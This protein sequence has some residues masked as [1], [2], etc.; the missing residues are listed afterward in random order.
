MNIA[1]ISLTDHD[2]SLCILKDGEVH[3]NILEERLSTTK[4]DGNFF[5][6]SAQLSKFEQE[7]GLDKIYIA[8][9]NDE[10]LKLIELYLDKYNINCP[11]EYILEEHHLYH[12][13]SAYYSSGFDEAICLVMDGWGSCHQLIDIFYILGEVND[14]NIDDLSS[15]PEVIFAETTS[16]YHAKNNSF[17]PMYKNYFIPPAS[18]GSYSQSEHIP[19]KYHSII[20][21]SSL[22]DINPCTDIG[23]MYGTVTDHLGFSRE[24]GGKTMGL[25]AYG[26]EDPELPSFMNDTKLFGNSNLFYHSRLF[27]WT[28]HPHLSHDDNFQK[29]ANIAYKLQRSVEDAIVLRVGKILEKY[30]DTKNLAFSGGVALNICANSAIKKAY[31]DL[32]VFID[33]IASDACQAYGMAKFYYGKYNKEL[34]NK[35]LKTIYMGPNYNLKMKRMEIELAVAKENKR[36]YNNMKTR[37]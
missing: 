31:P 14:D 32:N 20:A 21:K 22:V 11:V 17:R 33:P 12:A 23:I 35:P 29:K 25:A 6:L 13:S 1:A 8:N 3:E 27:N 28:Y 19:K 5:F 18:N 37:I 10:D 9:G 24:D 15:Y 7:Y 34:K 26:E 4:K 30:P 16:V 2:C 36:V